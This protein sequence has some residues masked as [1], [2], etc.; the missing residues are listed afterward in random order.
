MVDDRTVVNI[1]ETL[2]SLLAFILLSNFRG[3]HAQ[4]F[5][6]AYQYKYIRTKRGMTQLVL[7]YCRLL[8]SNILN[9]SLKFLSNIHTTGVEIKFVIFKLSCSS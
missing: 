2:C 7:K 5:S 3:R 8:L 1:V 4:N 9:L 6:T